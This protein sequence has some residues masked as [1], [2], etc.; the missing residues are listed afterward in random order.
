[1]VGERERGRQRTLCAKKRV[2]QCALP[3]A[4]K[5]SRLATDAFDGE[6]RQTS[7]LAGCRH[8]DPR[9]VTGQENGKAHTIGRRFR[10]NGKRA[11]AQVFESR[12]QILAKV[13]FG[14]VRP[15]AFSRPLKPCSTFYGD[16]H[17]AVALATLLDALSRHRFSTFRSLTSRRHEGL[18]LPVSLR[19]C[20]A[21]LRP[22]PVCSLPL[23]ASDALRR[24]ADHS[25][26]RRCFSSFG[27]DYHHDTCDPSRIRVPRVTSSVWMKRQYA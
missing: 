19:S 16:E 7:L 21:V 27:P 13:G 22:S 6:C 12:N 20:R 24:R 23:S 26:Q 14:K 1:M 9:H 10:E 8:H 3:F 2:V 4:T 17:P 18:N 15:A 11:H 5:N 25:S